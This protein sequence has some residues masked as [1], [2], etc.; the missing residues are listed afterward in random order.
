MHMARKQKIGY[1]LN[2]WMLA[3]LLLYAMLTF[4]MIASGS[5]RATTLADYL[6]EASIIL[7]VAI[8]MFGPILAVKWLTIR[9]SQHRTL[10]TDA[11][12]THIPSTLGG[13]SSGVV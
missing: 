5:D 6:V 3:W 10:A 12:C 11:R 7:A 8:V 4:A 2:E 13:G 9:R 1:I